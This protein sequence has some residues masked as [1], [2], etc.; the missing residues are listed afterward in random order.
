[1]ITVNPGLAAAAL[2]VAVAFGFLLNLILRFPRIDDQLAHKTRTILAQRG[3]IRVLRAEIRDWQ[4]MAREIP[5]P[6]ARSRFE[7]AGT[8]RL[9]LNHDAAV[10]AAAERQLVLDGG[11]EL[12]SSLRPTVPLDDADLPLFREASALLGL[13]A[14]WRLVGSVGTD[15]DQDDTGMVPANPFAAIH[16]AALRQT[17]GK[18]A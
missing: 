3:K 13:T 7:Y 5:P 6:S 10:Q 2:I 11:R 9:T 4:A 17:A 8:G 15:D 14:E 1:M 12:F 16:R 18:A